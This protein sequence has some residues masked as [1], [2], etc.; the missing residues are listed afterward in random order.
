[1]WDNGQCI[2]PYQE[3]LGNYDD[4]ELLD[5]I[6][7]IIP[8][9][10]LLGNYDTGVAGVVNLFIIPYQELLGNYDSEDGYIVSFPELYHTKSY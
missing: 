9:Q 2:I 7:K 5:R 3:L 4:E 8:Y 10:E 1:M 6:D